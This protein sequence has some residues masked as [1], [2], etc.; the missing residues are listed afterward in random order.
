MLEEKDKKIIKKIIKEE[1][2]DLRSDVKILH[3]DVASIK[4]VQRRQGIVME[5]MNS[6]MDQVLEL[7]IH[8]NDKT[9]DYTEL[10]EKIYLDH[11]IRI[12]ALETSLKDEK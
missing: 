7:V 12:R 8:I 11:E 4:D 6:K 10:K 1:T 2:R 9:K 3:E 5:D